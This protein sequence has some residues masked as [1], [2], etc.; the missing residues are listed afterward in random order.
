MHRILSFY[1]LENFRQALTQYYGNLKKKN[2]FKSSSSPPLQLCEH[3]TQLYAS[4]PQVLIK[5]RL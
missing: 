1:F 4:F 5:L 3:I 2:V